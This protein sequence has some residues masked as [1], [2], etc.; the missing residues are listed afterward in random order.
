MAV[1]KTATEKFASNSKS[2]QILSKQSGKAI[3]VEDCDA[4]NGAL[5]AMNTPDKNV[6]SQFWKLEPAADGYCRLVNTASGKSIDVINGGTENGAWLHQWEPCDTDTQ[7]WKLESS[8]RGC[9]KLISKASGKCADIVD[10]SNEEGAHLQIW[11]NVD[12]ENQEWKLLQLAP[13]DNEE[14]QKAA[15]TAKHHRGRRAAKKV[16]APVTAAVTTESTTAIKPEA[17]AKLASIPT[18]K[19]AETQPVGIHEEQK[20]ELAKEVKAVG[21][22][23][24]NSVKSK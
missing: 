19:A 17:E 4:G 21:A 14:P 6:A 13:N 16:A 23:A 12:G 7:L 18:I 3:S 8:S 24:K 10:I 9:Y 1:K 22:A 15:P 5:L 20:P 2:Y 11:D